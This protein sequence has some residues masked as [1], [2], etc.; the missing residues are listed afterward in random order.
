M[1]THLAV[2]FQLFNARHG[3]GAV[4]AR[5]VAPVM[6]P[7]APVGSGELDGCRAG[8]GRWDGTV[9]CRDVTKSAPGGE[10]GK[11]SSFELPMAEWQCRL[12]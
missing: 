12:H 5:S 2:N 8:A 7:F 1:H 6:L 10:S 9:G 4:C 3:A 11:G